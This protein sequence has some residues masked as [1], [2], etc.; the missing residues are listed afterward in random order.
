MKRIE[1]PHR[2]LGSAGFTLPAVLIIVGALLIL[3]IGLL[4]VTGIERRTARSYVDLGRAEM[5]ATAGIEEVKSILGKG[6]ETDDFIILGANRGESLEKGKSK[7]PYLLLARGKAGESSASFSYIPLFSATTPPVKSNAQGLV[8]PLVD[9]MVSQKEDDRIDFETVPYQDKVRT[10][11]VKM[12]DSQG[13][14][15]GRYSYWVE[16][17]Q[18]RVD[19]K[20][21]GNA[22]GAGGTAMVNEYPFPAP[23]INPKPDSDTE[24]NLTQISLD[25]INP[26]STPQKPGSLGKEIIDNRKILISP[27]SVLAAVNAAPPLERDDVT[28]RLTNVKER[29]AEESLSATIRPYEEQA[30]V[31]YAIGIAPEYSGKPK[32]N[33]NAILDK[34][35]QGVEEMGDFIDNAL[36]RFSQTRKGG[37]PENYAQTLAANA[38]DYAD[39]DPAP[40]IKKDVYRGL[41]GYPLVSE[42]VMKVR[43]EGVVVENGTKYVLMSTTHYAELWNMSN[44]E[45]TGTDVQLSHET[46]Y[47]FPLGANPN[48]AILNNFTVATP[49]PAEHNG[50]HWLRALKMNGVATGNFVIKP[51]EYRL[52]TFETITFKFPAGGA[53]FFVPSPISLSGETFGAT[54]AGY[55]LW[56]NGKIVDTARGFINRNDGSV[57]YPQEGTNKPGQITRMIVAGHSYKPNATFANN[58]GDPRMA[59]YLRHPLDGNTYPGNYSPARRNIRWD[60][61]YRSDGPTKGL[62]YGRVLPAEWPDGGH[63]SIYGSNVFVGTATVLTNPDDTMYFSGLPSAVP[64]EAPLRLSTIKKDYGLSQRFYSATELGRIYDPIMWDTLAATPGNPWGDVLT[65]TNPS[66][67]FGGGNTLRIGRPEHPKLNTPYSHAARLLDLFHAGISRSEDKSKREGPV[68]RIDGNIN[69]NTASRD[70]LRAM[71]A[72]YLKMDP[73][74]ATRTSDNHTLGTR[75]APPVSLIQLTAPQISV[76]ADRIADA[77]IRGRPYAT[78]SEMA[79]ALDT[80][81]KVSVFNVGAGTPAQDVLDG[82][83][84]VFGNRLMY[85]QNTKIEWTDSAAEEVFA[86]VYEASTVRSRNFRV[87]VVG[88]SVAPTGRTNS[89]PEVLAEVRKA[90][91]VFADPGERRSD[92]SI[93]PKKLKITVT[94]EKAF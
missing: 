26:E 66:P 16:D 73:L 45:I 75:M 13:R 54:Q 58:M 38:I 49:K 68:I 29:A 24:P 40:I 1:H 61:V 11:W 8:V 70:A 83:L 67:Y 55:H 17:L 59:Y 39:E 44:Q 31:P 4:T 2:T 90:F 19:A 72:G 93:D 25:A 3:A 56:W 71:A 86:R 47:R 10:S 32:M 60:T 7:S 50:Y 30:L 89:T 22:D 42:F 9:D 79:G 52:V 15:V 69:I 63:N 51:N 41:D 64:G 28:G 88:Q 81:G 91:T 87:W 43:W 23:G 35:E 84:N 5:A 14:M 57:H 76:Q 62:V 92:G 6:T 80:D 20:T 85:P 21:A 12:Y 18:G 94:H 27:D 48:G 78:P 37:F 53:S 77:I 74:L 65:T 34:G 82:K 33:L 46:K 36:P